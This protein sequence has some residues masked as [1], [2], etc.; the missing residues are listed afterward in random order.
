MSHTVCVIHAR[1]CS[2]HEQSA[3]AGGPGAAAGG[4]PAGRGVRGVATPRPRRP[5][6]PQPDVPLL[7]AAAARRLP[8]GPRDRGHQRRRRHAHRRHPGGALPPES[9][10]TRTFCGTC[11]PRVHRLFVARMRNMPCAA[12]S[13]TSIDPRRQFSLSA[14]TEAR[15]RLSR[16]SGP[17]VQAHAV[18][19]SC[20]C[21]LWL[22]VQFDAAKP[23][24]ATLCSSSHR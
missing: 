17:C 16:A 8:E 10:H 3:C 1:S 5:P 6:R 18:L 22:L 11:M 12:C 20:H 7:T 9:P 24:A 13:V 15:L 23:A 4:F 21:L 2:W 19:S 14:D